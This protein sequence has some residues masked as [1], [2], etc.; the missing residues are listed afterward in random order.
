MSFDLL[1]NN[2]ICKVDFTKRPDVESVIIRIESVKA[3]V[4]SDPSVDTA[5]ETLNTRINSRTIS[6]DERTM[7]SR[8]MIKELSSMNLDAQNAPNITDSTGLHFQKMSNLCVYFATMSAVRHE[9][10]KILENSTSTAVNMRNGY[11]KSVRLIPIP[12]GKSI[13]ELLKEKT[14][15]GIKENFPNA[16]CFERMLAVL[17]GCVSPRALSGLVNPSN[18]QLGNLNIFRFQQF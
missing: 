16:L 3:N 10:R 7:G 6:V 15:Q 8:D 13:D 2:N 5:W 18:I 1:F 12:A 11:F 14:F 9:M 4:L 17:L